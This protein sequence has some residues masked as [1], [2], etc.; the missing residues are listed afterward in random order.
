MHIITL[1]F[2]PDDG[3]VQVIGS[4]PLDLA[5]IRKV[6]S[7]GLSGIA[8]REMRERIEQEIAE[9]AAQELVSEPPVLDG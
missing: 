9:K 8:E 5:T 6:L 2:D 7:V 1:L 4:E 3:T